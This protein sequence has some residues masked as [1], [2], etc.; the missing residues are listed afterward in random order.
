MNTVQVR[1]DAK[2]SAH[3]TILTMMSALRNIAHGENSSGGSAAVETVG[4]AAVSDAAGAVAVGAV[5][6]AA[7]G[8]C[9][10]EGAGAGACTG[11]TAGAGDGAGAAAGCCADAAQASTT[12]DSAVSDLRMVLNI[13][14]LSPAECAVVRLVIPAVQGPFPARSDKRS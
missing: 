4:G 1:S 6:G 8:A 11:A 9:I 10:V 3:I 5:E 12:N 7:A 2:A 13:N 14:A